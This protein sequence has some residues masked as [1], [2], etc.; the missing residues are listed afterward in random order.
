MGLFV[1]AFF[2]ETLG[3]NQYRSGMPRLPLAHF[4]GIQPRPTA[5]EKSVGFFFTSAPDNP[6]DAT[7]PKFYRQFCI[8]LWKEDFMILILNVTA[9]DHPV[10]YLLRPL[11]LNLVNPPSSFTNVLGFLK[12]ALISPD[13]DAK[14]PSSRNER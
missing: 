5:I 4:D 1:L 6:S 10:R 7:I 14:N 11:P 9:H 13:I 3:W 8:G 12:I 2:H